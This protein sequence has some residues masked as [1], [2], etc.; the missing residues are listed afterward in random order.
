MHKVICNIAEVIYDILHTVKALFVHL[1]GVVQ[2]LREKPLG[3]KC[4]IFK[5]I[6]VQSSISV[7]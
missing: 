1:I 4:D 7:S 2:V 3:N 5:Q 6:W